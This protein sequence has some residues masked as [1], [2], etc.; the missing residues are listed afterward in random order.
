[1]LQITFSEYDRICELLETLNRPD[2]SWLPS[3]EDLEK[4]ATPPSSTQILFFIWLSECMDIPETDEGK[5]R[6]KEL[7]RFLREHLEFV[8]EE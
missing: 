8:E 6:K 1:M 5:E 2:A 3:K 7:N 4:Y